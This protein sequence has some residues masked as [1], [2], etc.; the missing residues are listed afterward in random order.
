[1]SKEE[2]EFDLSNIGVS[3]DQVKT[4]FKR[5]GTLMLV[6]IPVILA[7]YIRMIPSGIPA[8]DDWA[9]QS[10]DNY[11]RNQFTSQIKQQYPNLPDQN[12]NTLLDQQMTKFYSENAALV[13][14]Q[15]QATSN[16]FKSY[17]QDDKGN[18]YMPDI[19]TYHWLRH[20]DN[21]LDHGYV[22][23]E[24]RNGVQI[25]NHMV[26]PKGVTVGNEPLPILLAYE[27]RI[28]KIFSPS[29]TTMQSVSYFPVII[30]ALAVIPV[31]FIAR[32]YSGNVGGLFAGSMFAVNGAFLG[33]TTWGHPDTDGL[34]L[35][36]PMFFVWF[37]FIAMDSKNI[38]KTAIYSGLAGLMLGLFGLF[39]SWWYVF[40]F[41]LGM[42][43]LYTLYLI[44]ESKSYTFEKMKQNHALKQFV[45]A[46]LFTVVATGIFVS[47]FISPSDFVQG[48]LG[49]IG[50][51]SIKDAT[52]STLWP[53]VYTTVAELNSASYDSIIGAIGGKGFFYISII[54][55]ILLMLAKSPEGKRE[56]LPYAILIIL[57][58]IGIYY[59]STKGI[60]FTMMLVPPLALALGA[61]AG[62]TY[63]KV[64]SY[65]Q[66]MN[67][68]PKITGTILIVIFLMMF[69]PYARGAADATKND[70]PL[71]N[72]AWWN[73]L[74][75]IKQESAPN[76][77]INSWWDFGHH[78]KYIADRA[79]TF[80]GASQNTPMAH[81]IGKVLLT[82]DENQAIGILKMLDCGSNDAEEA[83]DS[84]VN[85]TPVAVKMIYDVIA[86]DETQAATYLT[87]KGINKSVADK[88]IK[89]THCSPPEDYF[90]TS[91]DMIG[92]SGVWG[93]FGSWN[94]DR[95]DIW[96]NA[97]NKPKDE[98]IKHIEKRLNINEDEAKKVYFQVQS[99]SNDNDANSWIAPWPGY[100]N[101]YD[102]TKQDNKLAC[103]SILVDLDTKD[104]KVN[105]DKGLQPIASLVYA[106]NGQ[107]IVK[108]YNSSISQS[109]M[110]LQNGASYRIVIA[111]PDIAESMFTR[112][113]YYNGIGLTHFKKFTE[114]QQPTGGKIS[115]WK[116]AW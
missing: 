82:N 73:A 33:R 50:F 6:L 99:I 64:V 11:Y 60:R 94:F 106:E 22:G 55:I 91:D 37:F 3:K 108:K 8:A 42:A 59:A 83:L 40:D 34:N 52:S 7:A 51:I 23:D 87:S 97:R 89:L 102:C 69:V 53:N 86:M 79:V 32:K 72:D 58:Y 15:I 28:M 38:K 98:A 71:V 95:A 47:L 14:Q 107:F 75:K 105:T 35:M 88:V 29:I 103:G 65:M 114:E 81:W 31:F 13:K 26:A 66:N 62:M 74:T 63:K 43:G 78:F 54:G 85:D 57:W 48:P 56:Y 100:S 1:M 77:I 61:A 49:P 21:Y 27:Y 104:A 46:S 20:T 96:I 92:K 19:D 84:T 25:D 113:F 110:L 4:F 36:F 116:I 2:I 115:V 93:H 24:I 30:S 101:Q 111:S 44:V 10:V 68:S 80:D 90:I 67:V 5:Y 41:F 112:L 16:Q 39:W 76:A 18:T 109:A 45:T 17:F 70:V 12:L 9:K